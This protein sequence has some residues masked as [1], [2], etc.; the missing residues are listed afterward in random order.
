MNISKKLKYTLNQAL[1][2]KGVTVQQ[3]AVMQQLSIRD[4][5]TA[6]EL[7][8]ILDMDKP[9]ISGILKRLEMK[10]VLIKNKNPSDQ[11]SSIL[12]LT[13]TGQILLNE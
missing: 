5:Y 3:W 11:R 13:K 10:C 2:K 9:I 1:V 12:S 4:K 6:T 7:A 8:R